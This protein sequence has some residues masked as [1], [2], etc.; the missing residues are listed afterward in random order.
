MAA[1]AHPEVERKYA[2][3][4]GTAVP[5][6]DGVPGV[7]TV[8]AHEPFALEAVYYDTPD[9]ALVRARTALRRRRGG[10]DE[11]WHAKLPAA[12]GRLEIQGPIDP[13]DPD[14]IPASV[15]DAVRAHL[16]DA[17][18]EPIARLATTRRAIVLG[19]G[20]GPRVEFVDDDVHA[21]DVASGTER[22]WREWEAEQV[23]DDPDVSARL[24]DALEPV[25]LAAG[26]VVSPSS[27]KLAHALGA[28]ALG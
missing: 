19:D 10:P 20:G 12:V 23:G 13:A 1:G 24:L 7:T 27:S 15:L 16:G 25:L 9:R 3:E 14:A 22:T 11:G 28:S 4:R 8:E 18:I 6:L 17:P 26:A 2:V 5:D 21:L